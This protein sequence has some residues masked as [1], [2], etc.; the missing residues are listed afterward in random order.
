MNVIIN[1]FIHPDTGELRSGWQ[2]TIFFMVFLIVAWFI[3]APFATLGATLL[4]SQLQSRWAALTF[5]KIGMLLAAVAATLFCQKLFPQVNFTR[6]GFSL[7][8]GW[9]VDMVGGSLAGIGL[10]SLVLGLTVLV[11]KATLQ[12]VSLSLIPLGWALVQG[13]VLFLVAA[14]FEEVLLRGF[15]FQTLNENTNSLNTLLVTSGLFALIHIAN[16]NSTSLALLNTFLAGIWL[17]VARLKR[18]SLWLATGLHLG[19]NFATVWLWGISVSGLDH[20]ISTTVLATQ[21]QSP[22]W[23]TGGSY[24][25]EGGILC[26]VGVCLATLW[27]AF[28]L[29]PVDPPAHPSPS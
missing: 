4:P 15:A 10:L 3:A 6:C 17:G 28:R 24:G 9:W 5:N 27:M 2:V 20:L 18:P 14:A 8:P 29:K 12:V 11:Q 26:T 7:S 13:L 19:W 1:L 16:P 21:P 25:P 23:L 22:Q